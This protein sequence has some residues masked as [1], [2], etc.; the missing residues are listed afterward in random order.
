MFDIYSMS[1]SA[2]KIREKHSSKPLP[3]HYIFC[4][5]KKKAKKSTYK[6]GSLLSA[7]VYKVN[8]KGKKYILK[9]MM[10]DYNSK[11]DNL[12]TPRDFEREIYIHNVCS[13]NKIT[14]KIILAYILEGNKEC[15]F[16]MKRYKRPLLSALKDEFLSLEEKVKLLQQVRKLLEK[17]VL[18]AGVI[19]GDAHV[20]N[21]M[22]D[23][24]NRVRLIDF[25]YSEIICPDNS[26]KKI[27]DKGTF[28][29]SLEEYVDDVDV[30]DAWEEVIDGFEDYIS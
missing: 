25:S 30:V 24:K 15:G 7:G 5:S 11:S 16:I 17:L 20:G 9:K 13:K 18:E 10:F 28:A 14:D 21:F 3:I 29:N 12:Y 23:K 19:H 4:S 8:N 27:T 22:L 26:Y 2:I 1:T 6:I